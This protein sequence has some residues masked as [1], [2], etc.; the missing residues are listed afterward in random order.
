MFFKPHKRTKIRI[1]PLLVSDKEIKKQ[2][3]SNLIGVTFEYKGRRKGPRL[4]KTSGR[5][6]KSKKRRGCVM[7]VLSHFNQQ[8]VGNQ[9]QKGR[10]SMYQLLINFLI[11]ATSQ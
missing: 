4:V 11:K 3:G 5:K 10:S 1:I 2:Y 6:N 7:H 9:D 8:Q